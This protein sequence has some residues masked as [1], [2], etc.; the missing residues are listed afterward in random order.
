M[1]EGSMPAGSGT[2]PLA[3]RLYY[4]GCTLAKAMDMLF[5]RLLGGLGTV[6]IVALAGAA[7]GVLF[8]LI[9]SGYWRS[10]SRHNGSTPSRRRRSR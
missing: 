5:S 1:A 3:H 2:L 8:Y 7:V 9:R 10:R 6:A 4:A